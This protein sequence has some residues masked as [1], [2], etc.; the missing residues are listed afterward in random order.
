LFVQ[1]VTSG[2][3]AEEAGLQPGDVIVEID[4]E[5]AG[6]VDAL[7]VKTLTMKEGDVVHLKYER[8][9]ASHTADL[10]LSAG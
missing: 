7:V 2:G 10:R 6:S 1:A 5:P 8:Q 3:P 4:G 9:G